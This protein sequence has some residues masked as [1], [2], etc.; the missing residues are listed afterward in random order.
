MFEHKE[1]PKESKSRVVVNTVVQKRSSGE[2]AS[3]LLDNRP[4]TSVQRKL[5][6]VT[7]NRNVS[8]LVGVGEKG[9]PSTSR[10]SPE[11][12]R[13]IVHEMQIKHAD[14]FRR[15]VLA[16]SNYDARHDI[17]ERNDK[18][19]EYNKLNSSRREGWTGAL[20]HPVE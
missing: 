10:L 13:D 8:Q 2:Q 6:E 18:R 4:E 20:H 17:L 9:N 15:Q 7:I 14:I 12:N 16:L 3:G 5:K 19:E 11:A 1:K